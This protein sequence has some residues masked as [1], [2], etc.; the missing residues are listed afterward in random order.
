ME[1]LIKD[2]KN[3]L[4][5]LD[6]V[7]DRHVYKSLESNHRIVGIVGHRGVGK[8]T[9]MLNFLKKNYPND[10]RALYVSV[11]DPYFTENTILDLVREFISKYD[12]HFLCIDE[13][14]RYKNWSQELKNI[15]DKFDGFKIIF[16]GSSSIN[17]TRE[18]YDLSR[19][20]ILK[21]MP[22]LSFRE[23]L[24]M[25]TGENLPI[26]TLNQIVEKRMDNIN[27]ITSIPRI[28]G[29]FNDYLQYGYYP[30]FKEL[31][32]SKLDIHKAIMGA[33]EKIIYIDIASV[34]SVNTS[35]MPAFRKILNFVYSSSPSSV[36]THRLANS[37][38]KDDKTIIKYIEA[39]R[40]SGLLRFLLID[41]FGHALIRNTEKVYLNNPNIFYAFESELAKGVDKG[42][43]REM[44]VVAALEDAGLKP[45]Y[46]KI[47]DIAVSDY[48][49]EIG[50]KNKGTE[51][52][53]DVSN[54]Y[55][56]LDDTLTGGYK[57]IPLYLFGFLY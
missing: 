32:E 8:T 7:Y 14:H 13:I 53:K 23:F 25:K 28:G 50:G 10:S 36:N 18:K 30:I 41:K 44:F 9:Y 17:I 47:G 55:L 37:I 39:L 15:Y 56:A 51:Q 26:L 20:A 4:R 42:A 45:T 46:S 57:S 43:V 22:G 52:I 29:L 35:A 19:R 2:Y 49:F 12:G 33:I 27:N 34:Q 11:D 5:K 38:G 6:D 31:N 40:D 3:K 1:T 21:N 24:E 54:A 16:S 48:I